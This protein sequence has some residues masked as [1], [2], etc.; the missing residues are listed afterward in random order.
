MSNLNSNELHEFIKNAKKISRHSVQRNSKIRDYEYYTYAHTCDGNMSIMCPYCYNLSNIR[1]SS[2]N[3]YSIS[4]NPMAQ[5]TMCIEPF[6]NI[7]R[8]MYCNATN[9][10]GIV[11]DPNI[12][13]TISILNQKGYDTE[14]CCEGHDDDALYGDTDPYIHFSNNRD[15]I[16][17]LHTL[18]L[19]WYI[20]YDVLKKFNMC[21]IRADGYN[22]LEALFDILKWANEIESLVYTYVG[23]KDY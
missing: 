3:K 22:K 14:H 8:C 17:H 23:E 19:S 4:H 1:I 12:S 2:F 15:I 7:K 13:K 6:V 5:I 16:D 10:N 21:I 20:D 11:L 18:P 9:F